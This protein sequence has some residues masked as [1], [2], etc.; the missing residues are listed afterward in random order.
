MKTLLSLIALALWSIGLQAQ[1]LTPQV[2]ASA[3]RY[4]SVGGY[5]LSYTVG[6]ASVTTLAAS[7]HFLTQG[8]QQPEDK[9]NGVVS[10]KWPL[11]DV[12][13]FP[14][15]AHETLNV[16]VQ[17]KDNA[18][19]HLHVSVVDLLGRELPLPGE[20]SGSGNEVRYA[21]NVKSLSASMYFIRLQDNGR[22]LSQVVKFNKSSL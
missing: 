8:F 16:W 22:G 4:T 14:N 9:T 15:P 2:V 17:C 7:G 6:E 13:L 10:L 12:T 19:N 18:C 11:L 1:S 20:T 21:F 5:S 3:G